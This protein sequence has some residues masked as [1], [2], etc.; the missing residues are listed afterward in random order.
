MID[1]GEVYDAVYGTLCGRHP[2][3]R[4]WHFQWL[5]R[6]DLFDS[7]YRVVSELPAGR[8]LDVGCGGSPYKTWLTQRHEYVGVDVV[9]GEGVDV[10]IRPGRPWPIENGGFEAVICTQVLEHAA[11]PEHLLA[12][13]KRVLKAG[14]RIVCTVPFIYNEHGAPWDFRRFSRHGAQALFAEDFQTVHLAPLGGIG[15]TIGTLVLN[16]C[17]CALNQTRSTRI[18]KALGLPLWL[19]FSAA[20]NA[21]GIVGDRVDTTK[22]FY[23]NVLY[24]GKKPA[25]TQ[26]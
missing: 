17:D 3:Q 24:V 11:D 26:Q 1:L 13:M 15:S 16:W 22:S 8:V 21:L 18:V 5:A 10:V 23:G 9:D 7:L 14:G 4:F 12:E 6:R 2:N 20:V 19:L 25:E